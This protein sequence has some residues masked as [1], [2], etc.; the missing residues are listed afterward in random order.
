[1][2]LNLQVDQALGA[3]TQPVKDQNGN[4]SPLALSTG[5]IGIGTTTPAGKLHIDEPG[6]PFSK[7]LL[8]VS[9]I[10]T[11]NLLLSLVGD[12]DR[13]QGGPFQVVVTERGAVGIG[14]LA[15]EEKLDVRGDV[16]IE[17]SGSARLSI[18]SRG[19]GTQHYSIRATNN[20][21]P[22]GGRK[23][24]IRNEDHS[25]DDLTIDNLGNISVPGDIQLTGAD[26]AEEFDL[27]GSPAAVE[28]G[29]VMVIGSAG[30]LKPCEQA[31]DRR[32][33][34]VISGAGDYRPGI[35]LHKGPDHEQR[36]PVALTGKVFC[37]VDATFGAVEV[38]DL[39]T[40]SP[41]SGHA[42][43]ASDSS[44]AFGA[45]LGKALQPMSA[46]QGLLP[47]LVALQ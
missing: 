20:D 29:S 2:A 10:A 40:T 7:S 26:C 14:T 4:T 22:A 45:I 12:S 44:R 39:L 8:M 41:I 46:G 5:A 1:M 18:R 3:T 42:M 38:G 23:F 33:A 36:V 30:G 27:E 15:P 9:S 6:V 24:I 35:I 11:D 25:R 31:Y 16:K 19:N 34:G 13:T 37:K 21:D 28:P 43:K 47:V 32:V 17:K